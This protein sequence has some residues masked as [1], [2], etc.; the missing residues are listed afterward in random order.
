MNAWQD[1]KWMVFDYIISDEN[2][3]LFLSYEM[4][5]CVLSFTSFSLKLYVT[6]RKISYMFPQAYSTEHSRSLVYI[7]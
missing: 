4:A 5:I 1:S 7:I 2:V 3:L 6:T